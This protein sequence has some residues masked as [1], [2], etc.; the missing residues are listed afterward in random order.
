MPERDGYIPGVPCW[1]D[2]SQPDPEAAVSFYSR[3]FGWEFEDVMPPGSDGSYFIARIRGGDVAAV[4]APPQAAPSTAMWNTYISAEHADDTA[5][6]V[7]DAGGEVLVSPF[8]VMEAGRMAVLADPEGAIFCAWEARRHRGAQI[9]NEHGAV[10]F[11]GLN[12]RDVAAARRFYGA[13]FGWETL[14]LD[15]GF[16]MWTL[17]G[18][19]DELEREQPGR[20]AQTV[21]FG[22]P[23]EF[24]DV[25]ANISPIAADRA[26]PPHWDVTFGV[27]DTDEIAER[28]KAL[29]GTVVV[30]PVDVPWARMTVITDPQGATFI[31]NQFVPENRDLPA[32]TN[33]PASAP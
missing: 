2:S 6:K 10:N 9:V 24:L 25:V 26:V 13:V 21:S 32:P 3:L 15:S 11:N 1:V 33:A 28:A 22:V 31:A 18:Y 7:L 16:E 27:D 29:G 12:T 5:R 23:A 30:A 8:D 20:R 17:P 4:T 19:G 14:T